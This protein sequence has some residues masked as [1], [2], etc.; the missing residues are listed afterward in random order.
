MMKKLTTILLLL[1]LPILWGCETDQPDEQQVETQS[2]FLSQIQQ[3]CGH[4][5]KGETEFITLGDGDHVLQDPELVM[6]LDERAC[7][8]DEIRI[9]FY[10]DDD[11]SRTWILSMREHGLHLAHDHRYPDGTEHDDNMYGGWADAEGDETVQYFPADE[12][13]IADRASR[14]INRWSVKIK[15]EENQYI[16]SLY[17]SEELAYRAV[18]DLSEPYPTDI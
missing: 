15:P 10:V 17:L 11:R 18:F 9:P 5:Y 14:S 12:P 2:T 6:V 8:E 13:T 16:Y 3:Y 1:S 4:A 7:S